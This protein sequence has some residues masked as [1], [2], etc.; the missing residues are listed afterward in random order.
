MTSLFHDPCNMMSWLSFYG[1]VTGMYSIAGNTK[2]KLNKNAYRCLMFLSRF[3]PFE[4]ISFRFSFQRQFV[5][6]KIASKR[7]ETWQQ[8]STYS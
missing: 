7:P 8:H 4:A 5:K 3:G 1:N 6:K 2:K